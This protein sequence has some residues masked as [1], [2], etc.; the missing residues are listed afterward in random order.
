MI[1]SYVTYERRSRNNTRV[2][3]DDFVESARDFPDVARRRTHFRQRRGR[4]WSVQD[5]RELTA[6][7][8][9]TVTVVRFRRLNAIRRRATVRT[10]SCA[11]NFT[12]IIGP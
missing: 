2:F 6:V 9:V 8:A 12:R 7:T 1:R 3:F 5:R 11:R 4:R 10:R